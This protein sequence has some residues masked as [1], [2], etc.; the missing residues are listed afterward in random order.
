MRSL[1]ALLAL[2]ASALTSCTGGEL[3][4]IH[5]ALQKDGSG[6]VTARMLVEPATAG[7]AESRAEGVE[8]QKNRAALQ[9]SQGTFQQLRDLKLGNGGITFSAE[10]SDP[11]PNLRVFLERGPNTEWV[12]ALVPDQAARRTMA[13]VYDPTG[14]TAEIGDTL[15]IEINVPGKVFASGVR[16]TGRGV[17][18]AYEGQ[19]AYLLI[20][21]RAA[22]EAGDRFE[23]SVSW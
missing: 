23:W 17:E 16:P 18:A 19:R 15:R 22:L 12:K 5:V 9:C 8:W 20:P 3:V 11:R 21:V 13:K 4:G 14:R 6:I 2:A 1:T 10:L 7:P